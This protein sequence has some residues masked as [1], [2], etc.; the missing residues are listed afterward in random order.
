M[1]FKKL[2]ES[3]IIN[4]DSIVCVKRYTDGSIFIDTSGQYDE[5]KHVNTYHIDKAENV[6]WNEFVKLITSE[7]ENDWIEAKTFSSLFTHDIDA[8][9][10]INKK[11]IDY[12]YKSENP[13]DDG[14]SYLTVF[15]LSIIGSGFVTEIPFE[16]ISVTE[17]GGLIYDRK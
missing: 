12:V 11:Y 8:D 17:D 6:D 10:L 2:T 14:G 4:I 5:N 9:V 13:F 16:N 15:E 3:L 1:R 7:N